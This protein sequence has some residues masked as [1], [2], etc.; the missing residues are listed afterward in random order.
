MRYLVTGGCGFIGSHLV[1]ALIE[2]GD[3]VVV[4]DDL[5]SGRLQNLN[6][7]ASLLPG[8]VLDRTL[9]RRGVRDIQACIHLAA[10]ASVARSAE[11]WVGSHNVNQTGLIAV[12]DALRQAKLSVPVVYASSAA[13]YGDQRHVPIAETAS[14]MPRS[15]YGAD[16]LCCEVQ[17]RTATRSCGLPS[18]GLRFFNVYGP[19]QDPASPY[20]GV[21]SI[22]ARSLLEGLPLTISGDG[23]QT[24]DFVFVGDVVACL[25]AAVGKA[26]LEADVLN[27]CTGT[28]T[29]V[30]QLAAAV[31][32]AGHASVPV[33][34]RE[35]RAGDIRHSVGSPF[36]AVAELGC[37]NRT[38]L[39]V[40][41]RR[42]LDWL[43]KLDHDRSSKPGLSG[44]TNRR[45]A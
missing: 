21:I 7:R 35:A 24:R 43:C 16:K 39:D 9:V 38:P 41:L 15:A 42:T 18:L 45:L 40:G 4:L 2:R 33:M 13:V 23:L 6:K 10:I 8:S 31:M 11:D 36:R 34:Y 5:S 37:E 19:R 3:E 17:A 27:V 26:S 28:A 22:F 12:L 25:L 20:S 29:T 32:S 1:D 14:P 44:H 30:A